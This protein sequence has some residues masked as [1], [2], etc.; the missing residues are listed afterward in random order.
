MPLSVTFLNVSLFA[1]SCCFTLIFLQICFI[2][3]ESHGKD[4]D[5]LEYRFPINFEIIKLNWVKIT[6]LK[7]KLMTSQTANEIKIKNQLHR[8]E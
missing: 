8:T 6:E 1:D 3:R 7:E 5:T 2:F 4:S